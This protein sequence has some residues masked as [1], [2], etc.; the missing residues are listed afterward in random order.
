ML[1]FFPTK[2]KTP[3]TVPGF[4]ANPNS[5]SKAPAVSLSTK[6]KSRAPPGCELIGDNDQ[7][8]ATCEDTRI[9]P[10]PARDQA[11]TT[12]S[13]LLGFRQAYAM[14]R[15]NGGGIAR[16]PA[17]T[18]NISGTHRFR[19]MWRHIN[20]AANVVYNAASVM[21]LLCTANATGATTIYCLIRSFRIKRLEL[22]WVDLTNT[23]TTTM[24]AILDPP[25]VRWL[26]ETG[27]S[28]ELGKDE[29]VVASPSTV[30]GGGRLSVRPPRDTIHSR[31]R[32]PVDSTDVMF[33]LEDIGTTETYV[34]GNTT[35]RWLVLDIVL[36]YLLVAEGQTPF[37]YSG[38]APTGSADNLAQTVPSSTVPVLGIAVGMP[39]CT[40]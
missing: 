20:Q 11:T 25:K 8:Y 35:T 7:E 9:T 16:L 21:G 34:S 1:N 40:T 26:I 4:A 23:G 18:A 38:T 33:Q 37:T 17:F 10:P 3:V 30:A 2:T 13:A 24:P 27:A 12:S 36:D 5:E 14:S 22:L 31:W 29:I 15:G 19:Q 39:V 32:T 28:T 6:N